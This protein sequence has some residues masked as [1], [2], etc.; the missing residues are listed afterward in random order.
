MWM[1]RAQSKCGGHDVSNV[2]LSCAHRFRNTTPLYVLTAK[3][4]SNVTEVWCGNAE[5]VETSR[6]LTASAFLFADFPP[7]LRKPL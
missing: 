3:S 6:I 4:V 2:S 7:Y 1:V 5:P